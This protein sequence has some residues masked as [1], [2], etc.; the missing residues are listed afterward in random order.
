MPGSN[1]FAVSDPPQSKE[2]PAYSVA[3]GGCLVRLAA[4]PSSWQR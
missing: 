4:S 2:Y 3:E 1:V